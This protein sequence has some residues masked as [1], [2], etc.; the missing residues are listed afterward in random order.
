MVVSDGCAVAVAVVAVGSVAV[1][2]SVVVVVAAADS[3]AVVGSVVV[4]VVVVVGSAGAAGVAAGVG[5]ELEW[6]L[7]RLFWSLLVRGV[8]VDRSS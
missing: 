6:R 7:Q 2:G 8:D 4:V 3:V 5:D 1:I